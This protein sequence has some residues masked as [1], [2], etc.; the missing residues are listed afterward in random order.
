MMPNAIVIVTTGRAI[1]KVICAVISVTSD[2]MIV[3]YE[4]ELVHEGETWREH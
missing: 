4:R 2:D 1:L 3:D